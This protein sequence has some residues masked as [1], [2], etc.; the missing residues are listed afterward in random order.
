MMFSQTRRPQIRAHVRARGW[1]A[2]TRGVWSEPGGL[3]VAVLRVPLL[4]SPLKCGQFQGTQMCLLGAASPHKE[5]FVAGGG[6]RQMRES[7]PPPPPCGA[8]R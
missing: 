2:K 4:E 7:T 6:E 5:G 8:T 3:N 1:G